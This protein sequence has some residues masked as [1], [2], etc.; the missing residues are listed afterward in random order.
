MKV[1]EFLEIEKN[2]NNLM[3]SEKQKAIYKTIPRG[4]K[5]GLM[6]LAHVI[7]GDIPEQARCMTLCVKTTGNSTYH[8]ITYELNGNIFIKDIKI[9][10]WGE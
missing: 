7:N 4:E 6:F 3:Y 9:I 8:K 10:D 5:R 2:N 1:P